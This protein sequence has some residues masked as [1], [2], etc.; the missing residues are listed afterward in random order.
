MTIVR[1]R[2]FTSQACVPCGLVLGLHE[3]GGQPVEQLRMR[4]PF[5]LRAEIV[6]RLGEAG[7]EELRATARFTKTR[8]VSG[9]CGRHQP[10]GQVEAR[11]APAAG[12]ELAEER[13]DRGLDDRAGIVHPVAA[14]Q[15]ARLARASSASAT[16]TCGMARLEQRGSVLQLRHVAMTSACSVRAT[17]TGSAPRCAAFCASAVRLSSARAQ[18]AAARRPESPCPSR[19]RRARQYSPDGKRQAE[20]ARWWRGD[21]RSPGACAPS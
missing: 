13:R 11:G 8:A 1:I 15:D 6:Q 7:A 5:A 9:F 10:V 4:R 19:A 14:R 17:P 2:C 18:G 20:A 21:T 12:V 3:F 16:T